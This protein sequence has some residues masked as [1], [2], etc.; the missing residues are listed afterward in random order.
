MP[1]SAFAEALCAKT[2]LDID[3]KG[4]A[5]RKRYLANLAQRVDERRTHHRRVATVGQLRT[6]EVAPVARDKTLVGEP[7]GNARALLHASRVARGLWENPPKTKKGKKPAQPPVPA[8]CRDFDDDQEATGRVL[9]RLDKHRRYNVEMWGDG[10]W[11]GPPGTPS[12]TRSSFAGTA[13]ST[14]RSVNFGASVESTAASSA[15][16]QPMPSSG[17]VGGGGSL[18]RTS[19]APAD[20]DLILTAKARAADSGTGGPARWEATNIQ[21]RQTDGSVWG[22]TEFGW[23]DG[24]AAGASSPKKRTAH[25]RPGVYVHEEMWPDK[26]RA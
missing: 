16:R 14:T 21:G 2:Q 24:Q 18:T 5:N 4:D 22:A 23:Y 13:S 9:A 19:F 12:A 7:T 6:L 3:R 26:L 17:L 8:L 10:Q 20:S 25:D 1:L 15:L 11:A